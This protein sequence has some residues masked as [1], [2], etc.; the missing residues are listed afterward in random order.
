MLK[1]RNFEK[2]REREEIEVSVLLLIKITGNTRKLLSIN[3]TL[4]PLIKE[5]SR[6]PLQPIPVKSLS[7]SLSLSNRRSGK[8]A[9]K[10]E[11]KEGETYKNSCYLPSSNLPE[12]NLIS[13]SCSL[14]SFARP[15]ITMTECFHI[16]SKAREQA[17]AHAALAGHSI[18]PLNPGG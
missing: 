7:I 17:R 11:K 14:S 6:G 12:G 2:K 8:A 3:E 4:N 9:R 10:E 18:I 13:L 16:I 5:E 15:R 1:K